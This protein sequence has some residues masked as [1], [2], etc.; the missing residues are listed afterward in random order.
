MRLALVL[1]LLFLLFGGG[2][3]LYSYIAL[4]DIRSFGAG[5]MPAIIGCLIVLLS[6]LDLIAVWRGKVKSQPGVTGWQDIA[7]VALLVA[8]VVFYIYC[9]ELLGFILTA[10][11]IMVGLLLL[12]LQNNKIL[13][14]VVAV[15]LAAGIYYLFST[16]LLVPLPSGTLF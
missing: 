5:F 14:S 4:G 8:V 3:F 1:P 16:I 9:V 6:A 7:S 12:F 11:V 15:G 10:S 2:I 13:A